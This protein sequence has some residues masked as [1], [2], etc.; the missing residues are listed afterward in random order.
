MSV[1]VLGKSLHGVV[2][3][4]AHSKAEDSEVDATFGFFLNQGFELFLVTDADIKVSV[5]SE[6]DAVDLLGMEFGASNAVGFFEAAFA[7]G[8]ALSIEVIENA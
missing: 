3:L 7:V 4:I 5:G 8:G 6:D 1:S 2:L